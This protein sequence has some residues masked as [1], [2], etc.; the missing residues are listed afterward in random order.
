MLDNAFKYEDQIRAKLLDVWY[1]PKYQYYFCGAYH[2]I[3]SLPQNGDWHCRQFVSVDKEGELRGFISYRIDHDC[4]MAFDFGAISFGNGKFGFGYDLARC[5][6]DIF[7]KF[8]MN[9]MEFCVICGNPIEASYD[10]II[11][12]IGGRILCIRRDRAKDM[13]GNLHDDKLYEVMREDYMKAKE[14]RQHHGS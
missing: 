10:K 4:N 5:I 13:A 12:K 2:E 11:K 8:N 1:D 14:R 7:V 6:D 3:F 9:K